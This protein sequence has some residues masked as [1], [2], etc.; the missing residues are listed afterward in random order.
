MARKRLET[1]EFKFALTDLDDARGT[2]SGYASVFGAVDS[3]GD[4]VVKG[5]F[6]KTLRD[7]KQSPILW[8]HSIMEPVGVLRGA[9]DE[10]GLEIDGQLNLDVQRGR[11]LRSLMKQ[12]AVDGLSIGYQV[13]KDE[14]GQGDAARMLKEINLWEISLC[15][16]QACPGAL[17]GEVKAEDLSADLEEIYGPEAEP[18][19]LKPYPNEHSARLQDP[20]KFDKF[21]RSKGGRLFNRVDVPTSI[22]IIWG[23]VAGRGEDEWAAQALRFPVSSWTAEKARKWLK[24]NDIQAQ[25]EPA[26]ED[27]AEPAQ[28]TPPDPSPEPESL[29]SLDKAV[30]NL[31]AALKI[32]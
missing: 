2:F 16:F 10:R 15:V 6:K 24:D 8:S 5:A 18:A 19:E 32:F 12:G 11:E 30:K 14:P 17:V 22:S 3:Y 20:D 23:H 7:K 13:V 21:R 26:K 1:K 4:V 29:H 28:A 27:N 25:F 31:E 9:E